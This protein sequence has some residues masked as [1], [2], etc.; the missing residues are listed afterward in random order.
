MRNYWATNDSISSWYCRPRFAQFG[1]LLADELL[2]MLRRCSYTKAARAGAEFGL[3]D[4]FA[5][6]M[7]EEA[8]RFK[9]ACAT[10]P[11]ASL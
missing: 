3:A 1:Q 8:G 5:L 11:N 10:P 7:L 6:L 4:K 2:L 9:S